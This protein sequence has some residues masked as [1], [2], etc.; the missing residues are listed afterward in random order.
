MTKK[1]APL[2]VNAAEAAAQEA[3]REQRDATRTAVSLAVAV[4]LKPFKA[5]A[6]VEKKLEKAK[7]AAWAAV[8]EAAGA[9][10]ADM[11]EK[12]RT[13]LSG[14]LARNYAAFYPAASAKVV[15]S[16][17]AKAIWLIA[18]GWA[19][20]EKAPEKFGN[21]AAFLDAF[22]APRK[23]ADAGNE[24]DNSTGTKDA[25]DAEKQNA[26]MSTAGLS[27]EVG[28]AIIR[29]IE[30][31]KKSPEMCDALIMLS[32]RPEWGIKVLADAL[33]PDV[34]ATAAKLAEKFG[35]DKVKRAA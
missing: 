3:Q 32:N 1:Q 17:H 27:V 7:G 6:S 5:Q 21:I 28:A 15:A 4:M 2:A 13:T 29:L 31:A 24:P 34:D 18:T 19:V 11:S 20:G 23:Q 10:P 8:Q 12:D 35:A 33:V 26:A 22:K 25:Q 16:Q 9:F 14:E 30:Q